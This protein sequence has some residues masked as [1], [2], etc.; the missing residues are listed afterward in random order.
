MVWIAFAYF[1][2]ADEGHQPHGPGKG[3]HF[4]HVFDIAGER[5]GD[6]RLLTGFFKFLTVPLFHRISFTASR[7]A[8]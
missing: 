3:I 4:Q 8:S 2:D 1:L 7:T 5:H 6:A